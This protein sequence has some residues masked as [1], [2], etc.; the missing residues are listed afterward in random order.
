[1]RS[2]REKVSTVPRVGWCSGHGGLPRPRTPA[3]G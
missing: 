3:V 2:E 1:L